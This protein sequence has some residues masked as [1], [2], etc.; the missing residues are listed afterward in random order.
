MEACRDGKPQG[1]RRCT[2]RECS[3]PREVVGTVHASGA[4]ESYSLPPLDEVTSQFQEATVTI[5]T[6]SLTVPRSISVSTGSGDTLRF[7]PIGKSDAEECYIGFTPISRK[8]FSACPICGSEERT[9]EHVP[10]ESVGG[11]EMINTCGPCNNRLGSRVET[12]LQGWYHSF[13]VNPKFNSP[14]APGWRACSNLAVKT[15]EDGRFGLIVLGSHDPMVKRILGSGS[16]DIRENHPN[17]DRVRLAILKQA[18][19]AHCLMFR[20]PTG[21]APDEV[22]AELIAARD[23]PK[24]EQVPPGRYANGLTFTRAEPVNAPEITNLA[25]VETKEK[26]AP[27]RGFLFARRIFVDWPPRPTDLT[28]CVLDVPVTYSLTIGPRSDGTILD[29]QH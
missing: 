23:A 5:L 13:L 20:V 19:L 9:E 2:R 7:G 18:Y 14:A 12:D 16:C 11:T 28:S 29:L 1:R 17:M 10:P 22:R 21:A 27:R 25:W 24:R 8:I 26:E 15:A 6:M 4:P 3:D